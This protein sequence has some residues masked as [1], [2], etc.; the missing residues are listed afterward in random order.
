MADDDNL[1]DN[2]VEDDMIDDAAPTDETEVETSLLDEANPE[3]EIADEVAED[4]LPKPIVEP[5]T[6]DESESFV[7][8]ATETEDAKVDAL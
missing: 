1:E 4:T 7:D 8:D 5:S 3:D 2:V 6:D